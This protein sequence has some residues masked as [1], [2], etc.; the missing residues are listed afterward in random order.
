[1]VKAIRVRSRPD[2]IETPPT[3]N[4][5]LRDIVQYLEYLGFVVVKT[6]DER[7]RPAKAGTP[8]LIAIGRKLTLP[9]EVK[10]GE[11]IIRPKQLE[12]ARAYTERTAR[13]VFYARSV[14]D[15]QNYL[16]YLGT[17]AWK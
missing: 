4:Q 11:D 3:H 9:V 12:W 2:V 6:H 14:L 1:M 5:V 7:N 10:V 17:V 15:V 13:H 8:D 16:N